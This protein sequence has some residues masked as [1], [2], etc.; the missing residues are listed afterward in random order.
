[1]A[2]EI[3]SGSTDRKNFSLVLAQEWERE[4]NQAFIDLIN[5]VKCGVPTAL[6]TVVWGDLMRTSL[7]AI[8]EKKQMMKNYSKKYNKQLSTFENFLEI[9]QKYDSIAFR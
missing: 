6:R 5:L 3:E 9:S 2:K 1:M 8:E 7:I 4:G